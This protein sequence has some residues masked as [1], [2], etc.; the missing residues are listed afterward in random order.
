MDIK[1]SV[2]EEYFKDKKKWVVTKKEILWNSSD[3]IKQT[4][5]NK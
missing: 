2:K 4:L 1:V 3:I 5:G